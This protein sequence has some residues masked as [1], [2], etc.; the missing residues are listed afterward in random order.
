MVITAHKKAHT[1]QHPISNAIR[2][3]VLADYTPNEAGH[4]AVKK[5][6]IVWVLDC[7]K[8]GWWGGHKAGEAETGWMPAAFLKPCPSE[9]DDVSDIDDS[10]E[11]LDAVQKVPSPQGKRPKSSEQKEAARVELEARFETLLAEQQVAIHSLE[12]EKQRAREFASAANK[13]EDELLQAKEK[14]EQIIKELKE[15]YTKE[16]AAERQ[17]PQAEVTTLKEKMERQLKEAKAHERERS[18]EHRRGQD[19]V[20]ELEMQVAALLRE[21]EYEGRVLKECKEELKQTQEALRKCE[22]EL[23]AART[24]RSEDAEVHTPGCR[25]PT[26]GSPAPAMHSSRQAVQTSSPGRNQMYRQS[27][28]GPVQGTIWTSSVVSGPPP[29]PLK[30]QRIYARSESVSDKPLQTPQVRNLVSDFERRARSGS[31]EAPVTRPMFYMPSHVKS[32]AVPVSVTSAQ[33]I[34]TSNSRAASRS[35]SQSVEVRMESSN[36]NQ[37]QG[38]RHDQR[39]TLPVRR[40]EDQTGI[41]GV[42]P[43]SRTVQNCNYPAGLSQGPPCRGVSVQDRISQFSRAQASSR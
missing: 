24:L 18:M 31:V 29:S 15:K 16:L 25:T 5:G 19:K 26:P 39:A 8:D 3:E 20:K 17:R 42:A 28:R 13:K 27:P 14:H 4:L 11:L 32:A 23:K 35:A 9:G 41:Y 22:A 33:H 38:P 1:G 30:Q 36:F 6:D 12:L 10:E 7:R 37:V 43:L 2:T 34:A 40:A 21:K